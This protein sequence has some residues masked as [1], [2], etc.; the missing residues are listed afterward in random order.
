MQLINRKQDIDSFLFYGSVCSVYSGESYCAV[1]M[2]PRM[3]IFTTESPSSGSK[4]P[5]RFL[6][7]HSKLLLVES[8]TI[9]LISFVSFPVI[10]NGVV[11]GPVTTQEPGGM[12]E[13]DAIGLG[14]VVA[15]A[16]PEN[17]P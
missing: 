4:I 11:N 12:G 13:V 1:G 14:T 17:T 6:S 3:P 9:I 16:S 2:S 8:E 15:G 10:V 7:F 5:L